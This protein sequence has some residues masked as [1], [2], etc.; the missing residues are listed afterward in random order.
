M[1][2]LEKFG[3][4]WEN[5]TIKVKYLVELSTDKKKLIKNYKWEK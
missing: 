4:T 5:S 3:F 1:Q 2:H